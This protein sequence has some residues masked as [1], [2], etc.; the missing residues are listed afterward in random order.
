MLPR[1]PQQ[2]PGAPVRNLRSVVRV[3]LIA[4]LTLALAAAAQ[5]FAASNDMR[6]LGTS[7]IIT[8]LAV[9]GFFAA[10]E[11]GV[12]ERNR[13]SGTG[14]LS[15][16]IAGLFIS[17]AFIIISMWQSL[18]PENMRILQ[19]QV[20]QQLSSGQLAQLQAADLDVRTL[21]QFSLGLTI[22]CCGLGFP[23]VGLL[24]G[25]MGGATAASMAGQKPKE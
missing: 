3:G 8:G 7:I 5:Q 15:G 19:A 13:G 24:L 4:G 22:M 25:A 17:A 6:V 16:L 10:R 12:T 9:T 2:P 1:P 23:L 20:E 18:D 14:A 21:T 11:A